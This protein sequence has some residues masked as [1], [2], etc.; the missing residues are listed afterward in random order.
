MFHFSFRYKQHHTLVVYSRINKAILQVVFKGPVLL[1]LGPWS[2]ELSTLGH[3]DPMPHWY[4]SGLLACAPKSKLPL[5][6]ASFFTYC[7]QHSFS[8]IFR[9]LSQS[10]TTLVWSFLA[11]LHTRYSAFMVTYCHNMFV[12]MILMACVL[13]EDPHDLTYF[14]WM[15]VMWN[16]MLMHDYYAYLLSFW[17]KYLLLSASLH[18]CLDD[19]SLQI[20][21]L[22]IL[23]CFW[24]Q[25]P[26]QY[27]LTWLFLAIQMISLFI[28]VFCVVE[29]NFLCVHIST[30]PTSLL[31]CNNIM[32]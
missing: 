29:V 27:S 18:H 17:T 23:Y 28:H 4:T 20:S 10:V 5:H 3:F 24:S 8:V 12:S 14:A 9:I 6:A 11:F 7:H 31:P 32:M 30:S 2:S 19:V 15:S 13:I 25:L 16:T 26:L 1:D 22:H 21:Q